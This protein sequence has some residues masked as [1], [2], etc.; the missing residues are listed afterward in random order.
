M[1][2]ST[3][4][5]KKRKAPEAST[6]KDAESSSSREEET[7]EIAAPAKRARLVDAAAN[8]VDKNDNDNHVQSENLDKKPAAIQTEKGET[9]EVVQ[10]CSP[11]GPVNTEKSA[12]ESPIHHRAASLAKETDASATSAA[13]SPIRRD[14]LAKETDDDSKGRNK[15]AVAST[16]SKAAPS[17]SSS[18]SSPKKKAAKKKAPPSSPKKKTPP[19]KRKLPSTSEEEATNTDRKG[20]A[21]QAGTPKKAA[22]TKEKLPSSAKA[23]NSGSEDGAP[24]T[25][26]AQKSPPTGAQQTPESTKPPLPSLPKPANGPHYT[27]QECV[28]V[29]SSLPRNQ[30]R[31]LIQEKI[32]NKLVPVGTTQIYDVLARARKGE[33]FSDRMWGVKGRP[34]KLSD[35]QLVAIM[36]DLGRRSGDTSTKVRLDQEEFKRPA[37]I[38]MPIS[39]CKQTIRKYEKKLARLTKV[40]GPMAGTPNSQNT[41]NR[42]AAESL[43]VAQTT[44]LARAK[45]KKVS[46]ATTA[47]DNV[48][49]T[50]R[51]RATSQSADTESG[52][53]QQSSPHGRPVLASPDSN[54][55]DATTAVFQVKPPGSTGR[56]SVRKA[57]P[58]P[59]LPPLP[60]P[61]NGPHYT[62]EELVYVVASIPKL[63]RGRAI[64]EQIAHKLAPVSGTQIYDIL[65]KAKDG[66]PYAGKPWGARGRPRLLDDEQLVAI[67]AD[68]ERKKGGSFG[69]E[70]FI[71][72]LEEVH[73]RPIIEKGR[74]PVMPRV[75]P[76]RTTFRN[77]TARLS[78][79]KEANASSKSASSVTGTRRTAEDEMISEILGDLAGDNNRGTDVQA[80][81]E[82]ENDRIRAAIR[83]FDNERGAAQPTA[84]VRQV[85]AANADPNARNLT[86]TARPGRACGIA[87]VQVDLVSLPEPANGPHYSKP[88]LASVLSSLPKKVRCTVVREKI[89]HK[90]VPVG[91]T[92]IYDI[93]KKARDGEPYA[94]IPWG[95]PGRPKKAAGLAPR[96]KKIKLKR[97]HD[98]PLILPDPENAPYY[99]KEELISVLSLIPPYKRGKAIKEKIAHKLVP[100]SHTVIYEML[101]KAKAGEP[102]AQRPWGYR[103]RPRL[104]D[105]EQ[106]VA[107][108]ADVERKNGKSAGK[109]EIMAEIEEVHRRP[110]IEKGRAPVLPSRIPS[111]ATFRNYYARLS[112]MAEGGAAAN[113]SASSENETEKR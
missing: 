27:R 97:E 75:I 57:K 99:T 73:R 6:P 77:Y 101:K 110:I 33:P 34:R 65:K 16:A 52:T 53:V 61:A 7:N 76:C 103:G 59:P 78:K 71:S 66:E 55:P 18:S 85:A 31:K 90:L 41:A 98:G 47:D 25:V 48:V 107:I 106:L 44:P 87:A 32:A 39:A 29:L 9:S 22:Q 51:K 112:R 13:E 50:D 14:A 82:T 60:A 26:A 23:A 38:K 100:V 91:Y 89:A 74:S 68:L 46:D 2:L 63:G 37:A 86:T 92:Q 72:E 43:K 111:K 42:D 3:W 84:P 96:K 17:S 108:K 11:K 95:H 20:A 88:E 4:Y 56:K 69:D 104:L 24:G 70:E 49:E 58:L 109:K 64:R 67:K 81:Q 5:T 62:K 40:I 19:T 105:D 21:K 83:A 10:P 8:V 15:M 45:K 113:G 79:L 36:D 102:Y 30:R 35:F 12:A 54:S 1:P 94:D 80:V 93:W 28:D